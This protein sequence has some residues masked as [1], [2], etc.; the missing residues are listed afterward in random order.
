M[1][2]NIFSKKNINLVVG[3]I[4]V[5]LVLWLVMIGIPGIFVNLFDTI[6]GNLLLLAFIVLALMYNIPL[7]V[8]LSIVFIILFRFAHM[9]MSY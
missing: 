5:L 8:G 7:G 4:T 1:F 9:S 2:D 3:L 6:L